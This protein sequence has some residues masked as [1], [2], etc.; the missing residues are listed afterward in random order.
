MSSTGP[1]GGTGGGGG[2][3]GGPTLLHSHTPELGASE[4]PRRVIRSRN[5]FFLHNTTSPHSHA[6]SGAAG[7][8]PVSSSGGGGGTTVA[9]GSS[10]GS[11][12]GGG[13][14]GYGASSTPPAN[15]S[16][17]GMHSHSNGTSGMGTGNSGTNSSTSGGGGGGGNS[18]SSPSS[19]GG[20]SPPAV[21]PTSATTT[22][23]TSGS[24]FYGVTRTS[25]MKSPSSAGGGGTPSGGSGGG[26]PSSVIG[27][28]HF[29]HPPQHGLI[30]LDDEETP[31]PIHAIPSFS[32]LLHNSNGNATPPSHPHG[33]IDRGEA[34]FSQFNATSPMHVTTGNTHPNG[35][36]SGTR[37]S[38]SVALTRPNTSRTGSGSTGG[39]AMASTTTSGGG[40]S[41]DEFPRPRDGSRG[42]D[43]T[44]GNGEKE[45]DRSS[46]DPSPS[47]SPRQSSMR[48]R[49]RRE[50]GKD[51]PSTATQG[52][53]GGG[54]SSSPPNAPTS[55]SQA[56]ALPRPVSSKEGGKKSRAPVEPDSP[57]SSLSSSSDERKRQSHSCPRNR[58]RS[59]AGGTRTP[60]SSTP[61]GGSSG[62]V[63][64]DASTSQ[65]TSSHSKRKI[66]T[67]ETMKNRNSGTTTSTTTPGP[68]SSSSGTSSSGTSSNAKTKANLTSEERG[69]HKSGKG[70][71]GGAL[72]TT[73]LQQRWEEQQQQ[74][75]QGLKVSASLTLLEAKALAD[76]SDSNDGGPTASSSCPK[77]SSNASSAGN[78]GAGGGTG[79]SNS[80]SSGMLPPGVDRGTRGGTN[81][82]E[83]ARDVPFRRGPRGFP[84]GEISRV[85]YAS[86][87][88]S[89]GGGGGSSSSSRKSG[90]R[91]SH[92][93]HRESR[94][95]KRDEA[96]E[97]DGEKGEED[98]TKEEKDGND[99]DQE[100]PPP[101]RPTSSFSS[102]SGSSSA[103][104]S[105]SALDRGSEKDARR[106]PQ[107]DRRK[108]GTGGRT[109]TAQS[110]H[111]DARK[112]KRLSTLEDIM[113]EGGG[114][115][116]RAGE[117]NGDRRPTFGV[118][119]FQPRV[120]TDFN[121][122]PESSMTSVMTEILDEVMEDPGS[123]L[124]PPPPPLPSSSTMAF[125]ALRSSVN[126]R[127]PFISTAS[128]GGTTTSG[129][130]GGYLHSAPSSSASTPSHLVVASSP[131]GQG[132]FGNP[133]TNPN[134]SPPS[135]SSAS[136]SASSKNGLGLGNVVVG[137]GGG[138]KRTPT[139]PSSSTSRRQVAPTSTFL[140][141][142]DGHLT[143]SFPSPRPNPLPPSA[144]L[145]RSYTGRT[146]TNS[147]TSGGGG[148]RSSSNNPGGG[149]A[150][151]LDDSGGGERRRGGGR[152]SGVGTN[153]R[154]ESMTS[155]AV[156][157]VCHSQRMLGSGSVTSSLSS[158]SS[159]SVEV[160]EEVIDGGSSEVGGMTRTASGHF[161][162]SV[163]SYSSPVEKARDGFSASLASNPS[164]G[165][166]PKGSTATPSAVPSA[167]LTNSTIRPRR[168]SNPSRNPSNSGS[169]TGTNLPA[170]SHPGSSRNRRKKSTVPP[171]SSTA[172]KEK[173]RDSVGERSGPSFASTTTAATTTTTAPP[174]PPSHGVV[175][176]APADSFTRPG[177]RGKAGPGAPPPAPTATAAHRAHLISS[178]GAAGGG[179]GEKKGKSP[180]VTAVQNEIINDLPL[181]SSSSSLG[182][183]SLTSLTST[184]SSSSPVSQSD[185]RSGKGRKSEKEKGT[186]S[187]S[188]SEGKDEGKHSHHHGKKPEKSR[189]PSSGSGDSSDLEETFSSSLTSLSSEEAA[190]A[191]KKKA[192]KREE[193]KQARGKEEKRGGS[194]KEKRLSSVEF[195]P[196]SSTSS[197]S[198]SSSLRPSSPKRDHHH[199]EEE[200]HTGDRKAEAKTSRTSGKSTSAVKASSPSPQLYGYHHHH[201]DKGKGSHEKKKAAE[202]EEVPEG[203]VTNIWRVKVAEKGDRIGRGS[204]G[205]VYRGTDVATGKTIA[206]K[207]IT[208]PIDFNKDYEKQLNFMEREV[209]VMRKLQHTNTIQYLGVHREENTLQI[210]MEFLTGGTI[211]ERLRVRGFFSDA[212]T[213]FYTAQLLRG[214]AYL[215]QSKIVHRDLKG[216][217]LFL[218]GELSET[219]SLSRLYA[220]LKAEE[221][222]DMAPYSLL[223]VGDFGTS[224]ELITTLTTDSVAGTPNFMAPEVIKCTG[225][226]YQADIWSVGCCVFEMLT[227]RPPFYK[228][229]NQLG[230]M[231]AV[232]KGQF[233][234][235]VPRPG[236]WGGDAE[237][238]AEKQQAAAAG[239]A[240]GGGG[241]GGIGK[242]KMKA[243][244][245]GQNSGPPPRHPPITDEA[246]D[247]MK[248]C[249]AV[250][251]TDRWTV[252]QLL[253]HPWLQQDMG[254][255]E[256]PE[257]ENGKDRKNGPEGGGGGGNEKKKEDGGKGGGGGGTGGTGGEEEDKKREKKDEKGGN[258]GNS[259]SPNG[260]G[261]GG[262]T[263][264]AAIAADTHAD[265]T[266]RSNGSVPQNTP[267]TMY[268]A[269]S[270][271]NT[272]H[273][274]NSNPFLHYSRR[275]HANTRSEDPAAG[276]GGGE[277]SLATTYTAFFQSGKKRGNDDRHEG[278]EGKVDQKEEAITVFVTPL[279]EGL[280]TRSHAH[281]RRRSSSSSS[282][283]VPDEKN[284]KPLEH[285]TTTGTAEDDATA[286]M[287][288]ARDL[289]SDKEEE[290]EAHRTTEDPREGTGHN[291]DH[292]P[293]PGK[294]LTF[295]TPIPSSSS[296]FSSP[297]SVALPTNGR[298]V[299]VAYAGGGSLCMEEEEGGLT[300][301]PK[302]T[303]VSPE[304]ST[305]ASLPILSGATSSSTFPRCGHGRGEEEGG[306]RSTS[307][308]SRASGSVSHRRSQSPLNNT[309][310][311][312][313]GSWMKG[314]KKRVSETPLLT[315]IPTT[316]MDPL[317]MRTLSFKKR[318]EP[319]EVE[320]DEPK[321][322]RNAVA[323]ATV[324]P[325]NENGVE[326]RGEGG[327]D[328][329]GAATGEG[330]RS[331]MVEDNDGVTKDVPPL[332]GVTSPPA[333]AWQLLLPR[334]MS[335]D[336]HHSTGP[337][338]FH[339]GFPRTN[340]G[341]RVLVTSSAGGT[342]SSSVPPHI[343]SGENTSCGAGGA[344]LVVVYPP[345]PTLGGSNEPV[346]VPSSTPLAPL[347]TSSMAAA[348]CARRP[349]MTS[350]ASSTGSGSASVVWNPTPITPIRG[351]G[352]RASPRKT[353]MN[354]TLTTNPTTT[355]TS[356]SLAPSSSS[357]QGE[358]GSSKRPA[359]RRPPPV[360]HPL[361]LAI[362]NGNGTESF[363]SVSPPDGPGGGEPPEGEETFTPGGGGGRG[364][365]EAKE[366]VE[367]SL[368][369]TLQS[370]SSNSPS[371]GTAATLTPSP[372]HE[373]SPTIRPWPTL[374]N[375]TSA[376]AM[377]AGTSRGGGVRN[378]PRIAYPP[379]SPSPGPS[380]H[381]PLH[382]LG[383]TPPPPPS[384]LVIGSG[385]GGG[386]STVT[387]NLS[388]PCPS[389]PAPRGPAR[390]R[391]ASFSAALPSLSV[392]NSTNT[393]PNVAGGGGG[394]TSPSLY[395]SPTP[396][397]RPSVSM[398]SSR[399]RAG[400]ILV[401]L[402][403]IP[404]GF[405]V[406]GKEEGGGVAGPNAMSASFRMV[407]PSPTSAGPSGQPGGNGGAR[408]P[409]AAAGG[410]GSSGMCST[411]PRLSPRL[412]P[413]LPTSPYKGTT[414]SLGTTT[415]S[416]SGGGSGSGVAATAAGVEGTDHISAVLSSNSPAVCPTT[417]TAAGGGG[418]ELAGG[419]GYGHLI[420]PPPRSPRPSL[421]ALGKLAPASSPSTSTLH[422]GASEVP[423]ES[424]S[425]RPAPRRPR[426]SSQRLLQSTGPMPFVNGNPL[427]ATT[428]NMM[429]S[430]GGGLT[431]TSAGATRLAATSSSSSA[432]TEEGDTRQY[433]K[434]G[435]E[436]MET[437]GGEAEGKNYGKEDRP[438][439]TSPG[440]EMNSVSILSTTFPSPVV[441][442]SLPRQ[443]RRIPYVNTDTTTTTVNNGTASATPAVLSLNSRGQPKRSPTLPDVMGHK[444]GGGGG[445][446]DDDRRK[447]F[448]TMPTMTTS[449]MHRQPAKTARGG[450]EEDDRGG[451]RDGRGGSEKREEEDE[452]DRRRRRMTRLS[453]SRGRNF[454]S[455]SPDV[456]GGGGVNELPMKPPSH[457]RAMRATAMTDNEVNE[458]HHDEQ[459]D[460]DDD[461]GPMTLKSF[462]RVLTTSSGLTTVPPLPLGSVSLSYSSSSLSNT[463]LLPS[464]GL[465]AP[466]LTTFT[467]RT[468]SAGERTGRH[469]QKKR[470]LSF[471]KEEQFTRA[472]THLTLGEDG[473]SNGGGDGGDE[474]KK[475]VSK[476]RREREEG[477][478]SVG[479]SH[480]GG[481]GGG[482]GD[483][484]ESGGGGG[485][486]AHED[487][488]TDTM[489]HVRATQSERLLRAGRGG[490][491]KSESESFRRVT[492]SSTSMRSSVPLTRYTGGG[493]GGSSSRAHVVLPTSSGGYSDAFFPPTTTTMT[494]SSFSMS[495]SESL[496]TALH[497]HT[498]SRT[499]ET[500]PRY[501]AH[502]HEFGSSS[503][504]AR[505]QREVSHLPGRHRMGEEKG[506]ENGPHHRSGGT[507]EES[508][509]TSSVF[510]GSGWV[511]RTAS[512]SLQSI[513]RD[514]RPELDPTGEE[515]TDEEEG[516]GRTS[517]EEEE[518][519]EGPPA[520]SSSLVQR[521]LPETGASASS[522]SLF[523]TT[524]P[525]TA[526]VQN[527]DG[528]PGP[529]S[530]SSGRGGGGCSPAPSGRT[531][532]LGSTNHSCPT[533]T[534][535]VERRR[536]RERTRTSSATSTTSGGEREEETEEDER[537]RRKYSQECK[538]RAQPFS[539]SEAPRRS[540]LSLSSS[541]SG[542]DDGTFSS[543][544]RKD[545]D[546]TLRTRAHH[547]SSSSRSTSFERRP[548]T[549]APLSLPSHGTSRSGSGSTGAMA[550]GSSSSGSPPPPPPSSSGSGG[551]ELSGGSGRVC[552]E[553][554]EEW[555]SGRRAGSGSTGSGGSGRGLLLRG[556][557]GSGAGPAGSSAVPAL[558]MSSSSGATP[559]L[560]VPL[561]ST[562]SS[563]SCSFSVYPVSLT[564]GATPS[565]STAAPAATTGPTGTPVGVMST[566]LGVSD[567]QKVSYSRS[568]SQSL[569]HHRKLSSGRREPGGQ[570]GEETGTAGWE[571][572]GE[573][574][575]E[576]CSTLSSSSEDRQGGRGGGGGK[577]SIGSG[578]GGEDKMGMGGWED[579]RTRAH[580]RLIMLRRE[581]GDQEYSYRRKQGTKEGEGDVSGDT[582]HRSH[583][584]SHLQGN[585]PRWSADVTLSSHGEE[586]KDGGG[587]ARNGTGWAGRSMRRSRRSG[588]RSGEVEDDD[589]Y[590]REVG[591]TSEEEREKASTTESTSRTRP[592][593][594]KGLR[595]NGG[596]G[597]LRTSIRWVKGVQ[598]EDD[599]RNGEEEDRVGGGG[600][601]KE[602]EELNGS[603]ASASHEEGGHRSNGGGRLKRGG[604]VVMVGQSS[605]TT[606]AEESSGPGR[607]GKSYPRDHPSRTPPPP[608]PPH[609][610]PS[611]TTSLTAS[612]RQLSSTNASVT[613][614]RTLSMSS[615]SMGTMGVE[616]P[617]SRTTTS[618]HTPPTTPTGKMAT[619]VPSTTRA[620]N[621]SRR[622]GSSSKPE[623]SS[624][625]KVAPLNVTWLTDGHVPMEE[626]GG[627]GGGEKKPLHDPHLH[628]V[629][630]DRGDD[631][632]G[633]DGGARR[634]RREGGS[635][636]VNPTWR[637][638]KEDGLS[639]RRREERDDVERGGARV[640]LTPSTRSPLFPV[641]GLPSTSSRKSGGGGEHSH[642]ETP[643]QRRNGGGH[644]RHHDRSAEVSRMEA[645]ESEEEEEEEEEEV[646][647]YRRDSYRS[648]RGHRETIPE[649]SLPNGKDTSWNTSHRLRHLP[650]GSSNSSR[651]TN[652]HQGASGRYDNLPP[653]SSA[654]TTTTT[655]AFRERREEE[656]R[657]DVGRKHGKR[658]APYFYYEHRSGKEGG[659]Q[660]EE[661]RMAGQRFHTSSPSTPVYVR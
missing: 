213:R 475:K 357:K 379:S 607:R 611:P 581:D 610:P 297:S 548:S 7:S 534:P 546:A 146:M 499:N 335:L 6:S 578:G 260:T 85:T 456:G 8:C 633:G 606:H 169:T 525:A 605:S 19:G 511:S 308:R 582:H 400:S 64:G 284:T 150:S 69:F 344:G 109:V 627:N 556:H 631:P 200:K 644:H 165:E 11:P 72:L 120:L 440:M 82:G 369:R 15:A 544:P 175:A 136:S 394:C 149:G 529:P 78:T 306:S 256:K 650:S 384:P 319:T 426:G 272:I 658:S 339:E 436:E 616:A 519:T 48:R 122:G 591:E 380:T 5:N 598:E 217:N 4:T 138:G 44:K 437:D 388:S 215:H 579:F 204:F 352:G 65:P 290:R 179:E 571:R 653:P 417:T 498:C 510:Y 163:V 405:V 244:R 248:C 539:T 1:S 530:S 485:A 156:H 133:S 637:T 602:Q 131:P 382:R 387:S 343:E 561:R 13:G 455:S 550:S 324:E 205:N 276:G 35:S 373:C 538:S 517:A 237:R 45:R 155:S 167:P 98:H 450:E 451:G 576:T 588:G 429:S 484:E 490:G 302:N 624:T 655:V 62:S 190:E 299:E 38:S 493:R 102:S 649:R 342:T 216:D 67:S 411:S 416:T 590:P 292:G 445:E 93:P 402:Q 116:E 446:R 593:N 172:G 140:V 583:S 430:G 594:V 90:A 570:G 263:E 242:S 589:E 170:P 254:G 341:S 414:S 418:S 492:V 604:V 66:S 257:D 49:R 243:N 385:G 442:F 375:G 195:S 199:Q 194:G 518:N 540:S 314:S 180:F 623:E 145:L 321:G 153:A 381:T 59:G 514:P 70:G 141:P 223:K 315:S 327:A 158:L 391:G 634:R 600:K 183:L 617:F 351:T 453:P 55:G 94:K 622:Q 112:N 42:E 164:E 439:R 92:R 181:D 502:S 267:P 609:G 503:L 406:D 330:G 21:S 572:N 95:G 654:T 219:S 585:N 507:G 88:P 563:S 557:R 336:R 241:L 147:S 454:P 114:G 27:G 301:T 36:G 505:H 81:A 372:R 599:T 564:T 619:G 447:R 108:K 262:I 310:E 142:P 412:L 522:L 97:D 364:G 233:M 459:E 340:S 249:T 392:T 255:E 404:S 626:P 84:L 648:H 208:I 32:S 187:S 555:R 425:Q 460:E 104:H 496:S 152:G 432:G 501:R 111:E 603:H 504:K 552:G 513:P 293:L 636:E 39:E 161:S 608:P 441:H 157:P 422:V 198:M 209:R 587:G 144:P 376:A 288:L 171:A 103:A 413:A 645:E 434:E 322:P 470:S 192:T 186:K 365:G 168:G 396:R 491:A 360:L 596:G 212:M 245:L 542:S 657:N 481:T 541:S 259:S 350:N 236:E 286:V 166:A 71:G 23:G 130:G 282:S 509:S 214:L 173:G 487:R 512:Q 618:V 515:K 526:Q 196:S 279:P 371:T 421:D 123:V 586:E 31:R 127:H 433:K 628:S 574:M 270:V 202:E 458:H 229:D 33:H 630:Y 320:D 47:L 177:R 115:D 457:L 467:V 305:G 61:I 154:G 58:P 472:I 449:P 289:F 110:S 420:P 397:R 87:K 613:V 473:S 265:R 559:P 266:R 280:E 283:L 106:P 399:A 56:A 573:Q 295:A 247:F 448:T 220:K 408:Y 443:Q 268:T 480:E 652:S 174:L 533:S 523:T 73:R 226:S 354:S 207:E 545:L 367:A 160:E 18:T 9:V 197:S 221:D 621:V 363:S 427:Y 359:F 489:R 224:K 521:S 378:S 632:T 191:M 134:S 40:G 468:D 60:P 225:H 407:P 651:S 253:A 476:P 329:V 41:G 661:R 43:S 51:R 361:H 452:E 435:G 275:S 86:E 29:L 80:V 614:A 137:G 261:G 271:P 497:P 285:T 316:E 74:Q 274:R 362:S 63:G 277:P 89:G 508:L 188:H 91:G 580:P 506:M 612:S 347:P 68:T 615:N 558:S 629:S 597:N 83:K 129:G 562:S 640:F 148:T 428:M 389:S 349:S 54:G 536:A 201:H 516:A 465:G 76:D 234:D 132:Y 300:V 401:S 620:P 105:G 312:G 240:G 438:R 482:G 182:S 30:K 16:S 595:S 601:E 419:V 287:M 303:S 356:S 313:S 228:L 230:V 325:E 494:P 185:T 477:K 495:N 462:R 642:G 121:D 390:A 466:A 238:E 584:H 560:Q 520:P 479:C 409:N 269:A 117:D 415:T 333:E 366:D 656:N 17:V 374:T 113:E 193:K 311:K 403:A 281:R 50:D 75:Q 566:G 639:G 53:G 246:R 328:V 20:G 395:A 474:E 304:E 176:S 423:N 346:E 469:V 660:R 309:G 323:M 370:T 383:S 317:E 3:T 318:K 461:E 298:L 486:T 326:G 567:M 250:N 646:A 641:R 332:R 647:G 37:P 635:G 218:T 128:T 471:S 592:T 549:V 251:P 227:G 537:R 210:F 57:R 139:T 431:P 294:G 338:T 463:A 368:I 547:S 206:I 464:T 625:V 532:S 252:T 554:S 535:G 46:P 577:G 124:M 232:V 488:L 125:S 100:G 10:G 386:G 143:P 569:E 101:A 358:E 553:E 203:A 478:S 307:L 377:A 99:N 22:T 118:P 239:G 189:S 79:H 543:L 2:N 162:S 178:T 331:G 151:G 26:S 565:S 28:G 483:G 353:S 184:T 135:S 638:P 355:T 264:A 393:N 345:S 273:N 527:D 119:T 659:G 107:K 398:S 337:T 278:V 500:D 551:A 348:E 14:G 410:G 444:E 52:G 96:G 575:D 424:S 524:M 24:G 126:A 77:M 211:R 12:N 643:P 334:R 235:Q 222:P 159:T 231:M 531:T 296:P 258:H 25:S 528:R 568:F 34:H 291:G